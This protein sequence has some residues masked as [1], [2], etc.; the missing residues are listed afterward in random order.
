[1]LMHRLKTILGLDNNE[2]LEFSV[3]EILWYN[4]SNFKKLKKIKSP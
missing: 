1:M 4:I 2:L 3:V